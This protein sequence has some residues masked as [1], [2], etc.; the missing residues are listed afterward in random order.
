[1]KKLSIPLRRVTEGFRQAQKR[2]R[3]KNFLEDVLT[4]SEILDID[5]RI[6]IVKAL[7]QGKT[8]R[9][10]AKELHV[11]ITKVTRASQV[12]QY[13]KGSFI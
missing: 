11:S 3:L 12:I 6:L 5:E 7:M 13:G 1:M 10:V 2:K 9:E 4:P 8:Q